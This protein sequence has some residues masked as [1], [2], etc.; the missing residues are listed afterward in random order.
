MLAFTV[1]ESP[2]D[3]IPGHQVTIIAVWRDGHGVH[4]D[5]EIEPALAGGDTPTWLGAAEDDLGNRYDDA[6]GAY[7]EAP[8]GDRT[9]G[10]L[11]VPVPAPGATTLR[12]RFS[13]VE[14][15][16]VWDA[17]AYEIEV[18]LRRARPPA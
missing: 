16:S 13:P 17:P 12:A 1:R 3:A 14:V 6:G 5:Y 11:T 4:F 15:D 2:A 7:G 9:V 18:I 10:V 8:Y